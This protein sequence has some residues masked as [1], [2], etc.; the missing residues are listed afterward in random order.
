MNDIHWNRIVFD[1]YCFL[2][3][4]VGDER[5]VLEE[6]RDGRSVVATAMCYNMSVPQVNKIRNR[7]REKYDEVQIYTPLLPPRKSCP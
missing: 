3:K 4:P 5:I 1:E 2:C 6:W 7:I